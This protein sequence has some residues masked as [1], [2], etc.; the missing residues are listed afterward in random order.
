MTASKET[1]IDIEI[2][3]LT[4]SIENRITGNSLMKKIKS[5]KELDVDFLGGEELTEREE[6]E[7]KEYFAK[8]KA[9]KQG[10]PLTRKSK[11]QVK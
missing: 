7:L 9:R 5:K 6:H 8:Q 11:E 1:G 2:D 4:R 3:K 10:K